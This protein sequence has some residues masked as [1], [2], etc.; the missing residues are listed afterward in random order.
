MSHRFDLAAWWA[1]G[2]G[3]GK[4]PIASGT[5][6]SVALYIFLVLVSFAAPQL[7]TWQIVAAAAVVVTVSGIAATNIVLA[8]GTFGAGVEDPKE[9]V[10]DEWAGY[11]VAIIGLGA[12]LGPLTAALVAFRI[13]DILKPPPARQFE[14]LPRGYGVVL[15]DLM[16]GVYAN[17]LVRLVVYLWFVG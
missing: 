10:I 16:A 6:A 14:R 8:R 4:S 12:A 3:T 7:F 9:V 17:L 11:L 2:L 1:S 13:F 15:D 5:A